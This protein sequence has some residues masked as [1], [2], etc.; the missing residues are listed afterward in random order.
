[1]TEN[2]AARLT[3]GRWTKD[4]DRLI[5]E[6]HAAGATAR[7]IAD[8]VMLCPAAVEAVVADSVSRVAR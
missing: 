3:A 2:M 5:C 1:M 6:A 8:L 4:R 7:E